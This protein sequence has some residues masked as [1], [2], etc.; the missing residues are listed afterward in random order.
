MQA[1]YDI[2]ILGTTAFAVGFAAAHGELD[3]VIL[4]EGM[5]VAPEF[6]ASL[7]VSPRRSPESAAT[8]PKDS[9][10]SSRPTENRLSARPR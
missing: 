6:S 8:R 5:T 7:K 2:C 4:E 9:D 1:N 3:I 10:T